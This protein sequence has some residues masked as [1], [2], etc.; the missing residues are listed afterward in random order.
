MQHASWAPLGRLY[1]W[2]H[3][4]GYVVGSILFV[5][6]A[7]NITT[8]AAP[9]A[10]AAATAEGAMAVQAFQ[11][12]VWPQLVIY[13][14]IY[15]V[16][17]FALVPIAATLREALGGDPPAQLVSASIQ[18]GAVL[19]IVGTLSTLGARSASL[20]V[21]EPG[22]VLSGV[23]ADSVAVNTV[24]LLVGFLFLVGTGLFFAGRL[25]LRRGALPRGLAQFSIIVGAVYWFATAV[26]VAASLTDPSTAQLLTRIWQLTVLAGGA[27][28]APTWAIAFARS[29]GTAPET[30]S[31]P[32]RA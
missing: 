10:G 8:P 4:V 3:A 28:L 22:A 29:L 7:F 19:G 20:R 11:R 30:A 5:L 6:V 9:A 1:A 13:S 23:V 17:F 12:A 18:T 2:V 26:N 21:T 15:F 32:A 25:G 24:W 16:A 31:M 14:L 27:I